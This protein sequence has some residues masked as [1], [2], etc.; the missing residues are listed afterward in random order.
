MRPVAGWL[1]AIFLVAGPAIAAGPDGQPDPCKNLGPRR[2]A[3]VF[4]RSSGL[5]GG[6]GCKGAVY[7]EKKVV[8][9]GDTVQWSVI[10]ACDAEEVA[11]IRLEGLQRVADRCT[12]VR[13][14]GLA[15][16]SEIRCRLKRFRENTRQQYEVTARIGRSRLI[17]DPELEIRRPR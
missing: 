8:C 15:G 6:D 11:D 16:A 2:I 12:A 17:V 4:S 3:I 10:N 9:E 5:L 7:P 1:V 14:L 13:R